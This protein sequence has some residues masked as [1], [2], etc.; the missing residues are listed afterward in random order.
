STNALPVLASRGI[1]QKVAILATLTE[2]H[3]IRQGSRSEIAARTFSE[4]PQMSLFELPGSPHSS[5]GCRPRPPEGDQPKVGD[6]G[7]HGYLYFPLLSIPREPD[8]AR[9]PATMSE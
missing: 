9:R 5:L 4:L 7:D 8:P 2:S 6:L 3:L 1:T